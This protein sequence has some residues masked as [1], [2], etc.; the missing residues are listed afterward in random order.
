MIIKTNKY[1]NENKLMSIKFKYETQIEYDIIK[2]E[3]HSK[4]KNN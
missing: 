4:Y 1:L 3:T 2:Y